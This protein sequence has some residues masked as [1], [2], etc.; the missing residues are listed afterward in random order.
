MNFKR[1]RAAVVALLIAAAVSVVL[2][3]ATPRDRRALLAL[4]GPAA[5]V[6]FFLV[7]QLLGRPPKDGVSATEDE[8]R[9]EKAGDWAA[10]KVITYLGG[11]P[12]V[13]NPSIKEPFDAAMRLKAESRWDE[14]IAE[15]SRALPEATGRQLVGLYNL[16]GFCYLTQGKLD[17]ALMSYESSLG[18]AREFHDRQGEAAALGNIALIGQDKGD[19]D[20]ALEYHNAAL[21][22]A[23]K[24][25]YPQIEATILGNIGL[26]CAARGDLDE[27]LKYHRDAL[28]IHQRIGHQ[29]GA[30]SDTSNIGRVYYLNDDTDQALE[31]LEG[32]LRVQRVI[33]DRRREADQLGNIGLVYLDQGDHDQAL[34]HYLESRSIYSE[35]GA[36]EGSNIVGANLFRLCQRMGRSHFLAAC[37]KQGMNRKEAEELVA[38]LEAAEP[39]GDPE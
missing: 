10:H 31:Y 20:R 5:G 2:F 18:Q 21:D 39:Q 6:L 8:R 17:D 29:P 7:A 15:T 34:K 3:S 14:A 33:G 25:N 11:L 30:A 27:A 36:A 23:R 26:V 24:G 38:K 16:I 12:K 13:T 22:I 1:G 4:A 35:I 37:E 19:L 32:A 28:R 9:V